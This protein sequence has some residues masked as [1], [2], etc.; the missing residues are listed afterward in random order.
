MDWT[1]VDTEFVQIEFMD[2]SDYLPGCVRFVNS[3][4]VAM[5]VKKAP[6]STHKRL[7]ILMD[8]AQV[9]IKWL[10]EREQATQTLDS[11]LAVNYQLAAEVRIHLAR[12][13]THQITL[14]DNLIDRIGHLTT[15]AREILFELRSCKLIHNVNVT[16]KDEQLVRK[17]IKRAASVL[18]TMPRLKELTFRVTFHNTHPGSDNNVHCALKAVRSACPLAHSPVQ[19]RSW[20]T[21]CGRFLPLRA[22]ESYRRHPRY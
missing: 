11:I 2:D 8:K 19:S 7:N 14:N 20:P 9:C 16:R 15:D 12:N 10:S 17:E 1:V 22:M 21:G 4:A 18:K 3:L 13:A 5:S 6:I